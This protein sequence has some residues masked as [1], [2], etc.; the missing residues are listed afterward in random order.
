MKLFVIGVWYYY[1]NHHFYRFRKS[2]LFVY[3]NHVIVHWLLLC[4][5]LVIASDFCYAQF[6]CSQIGKSLFILEMNY[7]IFMFS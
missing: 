4:F 6:Y 7:G 3:C 2:N 1:L 5:K